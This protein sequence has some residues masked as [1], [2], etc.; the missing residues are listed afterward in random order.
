MLLYIPVIVSLILLIY[1]RVQ[2][3]RKLNS[4][5]QGFFDLRAFRRVI[6]EESTIHST[7]AS[8]LLI[9]AAIT[10][11]T[12][13]TYI[14]FQRT[15]SFE[16]TDLFFVFGVIAG[17]LIVYYWLRRILF[18]LI[19]YFTEKK[20]IAHEIQ[21]Y[22]HFFYQV[23]GVAIPPIIVFLNFRLDSS[24]T[25]WLSI[26]YNGVL[27]LLVL[28]FVFIYL[29]KIVQEFRQTSQLKISGYYLF[30]YFCTLEILPLVALIMW[31]IG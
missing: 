21:V 17:G 8:L 6:R 28:T 22:N 18:T 3:A 4:I 13:I 1:V 30:L 11:T 10:V 2:S 20:E 12:G 31:F 14:L 16:L 7:T 24:S 5:V 25:A 27:L 26:F 19:G 9:N 15:N 29:F 23:L